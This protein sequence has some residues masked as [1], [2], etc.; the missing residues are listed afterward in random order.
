MAAVCQ[1]WS[2]VCVSGRR[3]GEAPRAYVV[4]KPSVDA[5]EA[6]AEKIRS[7]VAAEVADFKRLSGGV[8][9]LSAVPKSASGKIL[10]KDLVAQY[11][12]YVLRGKSHP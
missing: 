3:T 5:S 8:Q 1:H 12:A 2:L 11:S 7:F 4:L 6:T 10:K 9:F